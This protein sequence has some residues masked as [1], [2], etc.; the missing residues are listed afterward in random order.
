M[1]PMTPPRVHRIG[2]CKSGLLLYIMERKRLY[3]VHAQLWQDSVSTHVCVSS[4]VLNS[5]MNEN[6]CYWQVQPYVESVAYSWRKSSLGCC[7][8]LMVLLQVT[9]VYFWSFLCC[10]NWILFGKNY[11]LLPT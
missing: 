5:C 7:S 10:T 4:S 6:V 9:C 8:F 11:A 1:T 3:L 2:A